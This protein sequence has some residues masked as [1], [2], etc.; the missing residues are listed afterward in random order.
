VTGIP[1][2]CPATVR[3]TRMRPAHTAAVAAL[4][5]ALFAEDPW[6]QR[7]LDEE[8]S[9]AGRYYLVALEGGRVVGYGGLADFGDEAHVMTLGVRPDRQRE[10]LGG[11]LLAELLAEADRRRIRRVMLEVAADNDAAQRLYVRSGFRPVG[12]RKGYYQA[13]GTDAVVMVRG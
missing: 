8:L 11:R 7:L 13:T 3:L 6:S 1:D 12:V 4:E 10:G 2:E 9:L 5:R